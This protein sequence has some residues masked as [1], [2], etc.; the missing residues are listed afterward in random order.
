MKSISFPLF[1]LLIAM[2]CIGH[3]TA[4]SYEAGYGDGHGNYDQIRRDR[5]RVTRVERI[6]Y[7][8][9]RYEDDPYLRQ[10]CW[11]ERTQRHESGYYRDQSGRLYRGDDSGKSTRT[12]IGALIGGALGNQVGSGDGR[13]AA[14]IAG[15]V[16]GAQ[17]GKNTRAND[18][19]DAYDYYRDTSGTERRCRTIG[20]GVRDAYRVSYN[21]SGKSYE[22][23]TDVKP[24]RT[25]WVLVD[26]RLESGQLGPNR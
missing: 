21:Y 7:Q 15:A 9:D 8:G 24:G 22:A 18:R 3:A 26:V 10:E 23:I 5:A 17:V 25:V 12:L 2:S 20:G 14:T 11:D 4:Q 19:H 6:S 16:I 13:T 1:P